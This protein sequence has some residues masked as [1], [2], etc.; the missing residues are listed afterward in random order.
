MQK[1]IY[2]ILI[3]LKDKKLVRVFKNMSLLFF[4]QLC[5]YLVPILE[6]PILARS[7]GVHEYGKIVMVQSVALLAS[8]LVE[9]GFSLSAARK[10]SLVKS[11]VEGLAK[12]FGEVLSAKIIIALVLLL[13]FSVFY[14]MLDSSHLSKEVVFFGFLYFLAFGFSPF[15]F[16]QGLEDITIVVIIEIFLRFSS[17][18]CLFLFVTAPVDGT[19][20]L[21]VLAGFAVL[22][23]LLGYILYFRVSCCFKI[24]LIGGMHQI[25]EGFHVFVYKSSNNILLSS[26]PALVG[27]FC[28]KVAVAS[29]VP[30]EKIVRGFVGFIN[31][32]L[33]GFFPHLSRQYSSSVNSALKLSW[34]IIGAVFLLGIASAF[35]I[36]IFG[37]YVIARVLGSDFIG[38][39]S[40]LNIFVWIIP[41]RMANQAVGL[42]MLIPRGL[43]RVASRSILIFAV[44]SII[45]AGILSKMYGVEGIVYGFLIAE[46]L[47]L[48]SLLF[49]S[50][51]ANDSYKRYH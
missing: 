10:V 33:I 50:F 17:L 38:A 3:L 4:V 36:S 27:L 26:G 46:L 49:L 18:L 45:L 47:L 41:L 12:I 25:Y 13:L 19:L 22:N 11:D 8:L 31:P 40:V 23:S 39:A 7:L 1:S 20:A 30:A 37:Q 51:K 48:I 34:I 28:G 9:Y 14:I 15:W 29:Y 5:G 35:F 21:M 24:S 44:I 32:V 2:K 42:C 6:V 43:D 16:F